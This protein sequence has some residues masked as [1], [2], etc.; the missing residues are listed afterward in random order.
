[1]SMSAVGRI[2]ASKLAGATRGTTAGES[3][4]S[5]PAHDPASAPDGLTATGP[6]AK[7]APISTALMLAL[8]ES[9]TSEAGDR[10]ARHH[11][12]QLLAALAELQHALLSDNHGGALDQLLLLVKT[13]P[14]AT[15]PALVRTINSIRLRARIELARAHPTM[16]VVRHPDA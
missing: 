7:A 16:D 3:G 15:D 8:Q 14:D 11:G 13:I 4:F 1:M 6:T 12:Q 2:V 5:I 10:E 9:M